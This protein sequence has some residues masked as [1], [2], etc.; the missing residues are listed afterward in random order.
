MFTRYLFALPLRSA[1]AELVAKALTS[2]FFRHAYLPKTIL[3]DLG[4]VFTANLINNLTKMLGIQ[5]KH[6]T[7]KHPQTIGLLERSHA[8]F[9]RALKVNENQLSSDWYNYVDVATFAHNTTYHKAI[10]CPPSLLFHG[11]EPHTSVDLR[12]K[13]SAE[14]Q[15][16]N[17][18]EYISKLHNRMSQ[19]FANARQNLVTSY[20]QNR[21][22]YDRK[23]AASPLQLYS[24]CLLLDP[25]ISNPN[26]SFKK[27]KSKWLPLYRVE[28]ILTHSIY[29]VRKVGTHYTHLVH[30]IRLRPIKPQF[31][32]NDL[33]EVDPSKFETLPNIEQHE[34]E[35]YLLDAYIETSLEIS[36]EPD[37][38]EVQFDNSPSET[39]YRAAEPPIS[40]A[41][42]PSSNDEFLVEGHITSE[43]NFTVPSVIDAS[44]YKFGH[45]ENSNHSSQI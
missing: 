2:I 22:F 19:L 15:P 27:Q 5:L 23:C 34:K 37:K 17:H 30:R 12:F 41:N 35:P 39:I 6:A 45:K 32:V 16:K 9:K 26:T 1:D 44:E 10:G 31:I 42:N 40:T 33:E 28:K 4:T 20:H 29:L 24:F 18:F 8:S 43:Q 36:P 7:L 14:T 3:T 13:T 21:K 38:K 25:K 11:R